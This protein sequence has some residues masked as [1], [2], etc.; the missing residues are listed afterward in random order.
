MS[1]TNVQIVDLKKLAIST[2]IKICLGFIW[3]SLLVGLL[4]AIVSGFLGGLSGLLLDSVP[5]VALAVAAIIGLSCG[6]LATYYF[7]RWLFNCKLGG[8]RV[9]LVSEYNRPE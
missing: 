6:C 9:V 7:L 3:R 5:V 8:F 2:K 1:F 4:S